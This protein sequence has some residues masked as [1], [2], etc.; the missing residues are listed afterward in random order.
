MKKFY[1]RFNKYLRKED[2]LYKSFIFLIIFIH[3]FIIVGF[4]LP[5][6]VKEKLLLK[7]N[8][9]N[10]IKIYSHIIIH[11]DF[12]HFIQNLISFSVIS[13]IFVYILKKEIVEKEK[14]FTS[15]IAITLITPIISSLLWYF[16][17]SI[18][19]LEENTMGFSSI[20]AAYSIFILYFFLSQY[21]PSNYKIKVPKNETFFSMLLIIFYVFSNRYDIEL[22]EIIRFDIIILLISILIFSKL[23]IKI[24]IKKNKDYIKIFSIFFLEFLIVCFAFPRNINDVD[25]ISH[26]AGFLSG[27]IIGFLLYSENNDYL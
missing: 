16:N 19:K 13:Y 22:F 17:S 7:T 12:D 23:F 10:L 2:N 1:K 9:I 5:V 4:F 20:L 11:K 26:F 3:F 15:F 21:L 24:E 6:G 14:L 8:E 25:I 27:L 18:F